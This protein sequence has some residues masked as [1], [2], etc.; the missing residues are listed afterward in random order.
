MRREGSAEVDPSRACVRAGA[1]GSARAKL[2][3]A[4]RLALGGRH[5]GVVFDWLGP[6]RRL[7]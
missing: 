6:R 7:L 5:E 3:V 1:C 2:R 4:R